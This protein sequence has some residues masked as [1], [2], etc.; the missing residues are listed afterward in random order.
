MSLGRGVWIEVS[1]ILRWV[2][3]VALGA[4]GVENRRILVGLGDASAVR[5][6]VGFVEGLRAVLIVVR[7]I[8]GVGHGLS[9]AW[10]R[11]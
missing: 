8:R 9:F 2:V 11:R 4:G 10:R 3:G 1:V 5:R 6:R 7:F